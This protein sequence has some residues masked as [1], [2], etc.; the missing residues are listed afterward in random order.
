MYIIVKSLF[1]SKCCSTCYKKRSNNKLQKRAIITTTIKT[2]MTWKMTMLLKVTMPIIN[3]SLITIMWMRLTLLTNINTTVLERKLIY[4]LRHHWP[5][6]AVCCYCRTAEAKRTVLTKM[7]VVIIKT[8]VS[9]N[10]QTWVMWSKL[11]AA[12]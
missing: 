8:R 5:L 7:L 12:K 3:L 6:I 10:H 1:Y 11:H 2:K 9:I 4:T